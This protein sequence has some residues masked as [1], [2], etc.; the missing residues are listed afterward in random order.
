MCNISDN[1]DLICK[2]LYNKHV[3]SR[4]LHFYLSFQDQLDSNNIISEIYTYC[5]NQYEGYWF[6]SMY[7]YKG[8]LLAFGTFLAY[9]TR[10]VTVPGRVWQDIKYLF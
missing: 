7:I 10:Q 4:T 1:P 8:L 3:S 6:V 5:H 9:E 2:K